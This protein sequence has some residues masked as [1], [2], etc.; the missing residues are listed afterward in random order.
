MRRAGHLYSTC[1][2][3]SSF[4]T[5]RATS[6]A[7]L[8]SGYTLL[9]HP[10]IQASQSIGAFEDARCI[11][12]M[13]RRSLRGFNADAQSKDEDDLRW[14]NLELPAAVNTLVI[15]PRDLLH[16]HLMC[17]CNQVHA[18][19]NLD[20]IERLLPFFRTNPSLCRIH[21]TDRDEE[22][23]ISSTIEP[24]YFILLRSYVD[25]SGQQELLHFRY[26][27]DAPAQASSSSAVNE[28]KKPEWKSIALLGDKVVPL[29]VLKKMYAK[30]GQSIKWKE[31]ERGLVLSEDIWDM[32]DGAPEGN[33]SDVEEDMDAA[34]A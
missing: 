27:K 22:H 23:H 16:C 14:H 11:S 34:I 26:N 30:M 7:S 13:H 20:A 5:P 29:F 10:I 25:E 4:D 21:F 28:R 19:L 31:P 32:L 15:V 1:D 18:P 33:S 2:D 9:D 12:D 6:S 24:Q 8:L 17:C 3:T